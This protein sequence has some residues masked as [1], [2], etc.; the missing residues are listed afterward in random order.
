MLQRTHD[1]HMARGCNAIQG[2]SGH[3]RGE[4]YRLDFGTMTSKWSCEGGKSMVRVCL[5]REL[6]HDAA[7]LVLLTTTSTY[8]ACGRGAVLCGWVM[9]RLNTMFAHIGTLELAPG[10]QLTVAFQHDRWCGERAAHALGRGESSQAFRKRLL[11][12]S[13]VLTGFVSAW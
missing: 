6:R 2:I 5:K 8:A 12:R 10:P 13:V 7:S 1:N 11:H 4:E 9:R 3:Q